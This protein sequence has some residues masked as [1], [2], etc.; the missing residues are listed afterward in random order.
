MHRYAIDRSQIERVL[1]ANP[2]GTFAP[3]FELVPGTVHVWHLDLDCPPVDAASLAKILSP[4]EIRRAEAF[5][6]EQ[7]RLRFVVG[8]GLLRVLLADYL[9]VAPET[10]A[11]TY[12]SHGKPEL[13]ADSTGTE[14]A[15][16]LTHTDSVALIAISLNRRVGVDCERVRFLDDM[17]QIAEKFFSPA[18]NR[19]LDRLP[20]A[21]F[22]TAF[23]RCWTRKEAFVKAM[24]E[25]L[26]YPLNH[27][28]VS[29]EASESPCRVEFPEAASEPYAWFVYSLPVASSYLG[30][31]AVEGPI[32]ALYQWRWLDS[33]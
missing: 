5:Q 24:G 2:S 14:T 9:G 23:Y 15:F 25:G 8:R 3:P 26:S 17:H 27:F 13:K 21:K 10:V 16:N 1:G 30:A 33:P 12:G 32:T 18:E 19:M 31:L 7:L 4:D 29:I 28:T 20:D 6:F 22:L 11:F